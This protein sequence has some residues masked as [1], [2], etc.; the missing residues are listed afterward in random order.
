MTIKE[1][2]TRYFLNASVLNRLIIINAIIFILFEF[3][4]T[5]GAL[6]NN[7][8][9]FVKVWFSFPNDIFEYIKKPWTII[10]YGFLHDGF[11]HVLFNMLFL[12]FFGQVF[13][14]IHNGRRFLNVYFLGILFGALFYMVAFAVF[15]V[16][17]RQKHILI[18]ASAA[19]NAVMVAATVQSPNSPFR[20]M[21]IPITFK[22]WWLCIGLLIMDV[23][24]LRSANAGGHFAH[25]GGAAI[26]Y[27]YMVQLQKGNDIG[28]SVEKTMDWFVGLFKPKEKSNLKTVHKSKQTSKKYKTAPSSKSP[29]QAQ[30]DAILDKIS[31]N[32]Y[33]SLSK[34][35]KE[36]L[37]KAGKN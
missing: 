25:L 3:I 29:N 31:K 14:N 37:F 30:I 28:I 27:I 9:S 23:I 5:A 15:P 10:T 7:N 17:A 24:Q 26:G 2:Y 35:E 4:T 1:V 32:G 11:R 36:I 12:Y 22:L 21:F 34:V 18:G 33:E 16:F 20:L 13:L 6:F 19:V 8:L